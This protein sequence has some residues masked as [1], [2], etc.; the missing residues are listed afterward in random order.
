[1]INDLAANKDGELTSAF[2]NMQ[3]HLKSLLKDIIN[4]SSSLKDTSNNLLAA[5]EEMIQSA[6]TQ[7][8]KISETTSAM[9]EMSASIQQIAQTSKNA[10][11]LSSEARQSAEKGATSVA[12]TVN[13]L[14][15]ISHNIKTAGNMTVKLGDH[16]NE[17]GKIVLAIT[18][19]SAQTNLLALNAAI[20][21]ARA[22]EHG[23]GFAVV[24]DEVRKLAERSASSAKEIGQIIEKIQSEMN[25]TIST[26]S[27]SS[28]SA[29]EGMALADGLNN[30]FFTIQES[31]SKSGSCIGEIAVAIQQQATVCDSIV[32]ATETI[33][34]TTKEISKSA[35]DLYNRAEKLKSESVQLDEQTKKFQI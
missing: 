7:S 22:G 20:E 14:S 25:M 29:S 26:I 8:S 32:E 3:D 21:A 15:D 28:Q 17:I 34:I 23:R 31:I 35:Y 24:A 2:I 1:V 19:I 27:K 30:S 12:N 10:E 4:V 33:D 6:N 11:K 18:E 13:G 5:F 16:S 9:S